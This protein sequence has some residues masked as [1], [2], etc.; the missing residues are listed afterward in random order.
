MCSDSPPLIS[1]FI[2]NG[3][4]PAI[5]E[6]VNERIGDTAEFM[7]LFFFFLMNITVSEDGQKFTNES[8]IFKKVFLHLVEN[9]KFNEL[10]NNKLTYSS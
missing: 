5:I 7:Y 8:G 1:T 10:N 9:N 6:T 4:I 3:F 2:K